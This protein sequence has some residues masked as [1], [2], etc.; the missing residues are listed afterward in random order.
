MK[1]QKIANKEKLKK[2]TTKKVT[3]IATSI[4]TYKHLPKGILLVALLA[5]ICLGASDGD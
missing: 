1:N 3:L 2:K 4:A 5:K